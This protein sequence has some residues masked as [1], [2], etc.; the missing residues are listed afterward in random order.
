MIEN[1]FAI[2]ALLKF[3]LIKLIIFLKLLS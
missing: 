2:K 1:I 3:S